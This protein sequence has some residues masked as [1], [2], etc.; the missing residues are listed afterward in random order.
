M[1]Q[2]TIKTKQKN[3]P[4]ESDTKY[5]AGQQ[6]PHAPIHVGFSQQYGN[7]SGNRQ[8]EYDPEDPLGPELKGFEFTEQSIRR[9]F[10]RKVYGILS[11]SMIYKKKTHIIFG[12]KKKKRNYVEKKPLY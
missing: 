1:H 11:V 4:S 8:R 7:T 6:Q 9:G 12:R 3:F 2:Q 10:L 5:L